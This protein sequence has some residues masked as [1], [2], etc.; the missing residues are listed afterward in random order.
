M[1]PNLETYIKRLWKAKDKQERQKIQLDLIQYISELGQRYATN[2]QL[3]SDS[4]I[5]N[6]EEWYKKSMTECVHQAG[7][8][9][10]YQHEANRVEIEAAK[11]LL[12]FIYGM[13]MVFQDEPVE[14]EAD[15]D[16]SPLTTLE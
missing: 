9:V 14:E 12:A 11:A 15:S 16:T 8:D 6:K 2:L 1:Q 4:V 13:E 7:R 10:G 5:R 3:Y